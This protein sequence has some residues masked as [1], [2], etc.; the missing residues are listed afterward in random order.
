MRQKAGFRWMSLLLLFCLA[1]RPAQSQR[2]YAVLAGV[3]DYQYDTLFNDLTD[4]RFS[5]DDA[6][7]M[8]HLLK[9]NPGEVV[10]LTDTLATKSNILATARRVFEKAGK[11]DRILF[12][13][14]GHGVPGAFLP[15]DFSGDNFLLHSEIKEAFRLSQ[16][17]V[18]VCIADACYAGSIRRKSTPSAAAPPA[19]ADKGPDVV[20][21]MSSR[22][23][24]TSQEYVRLQRG[25]FTHFLLEALHG[26]A[27][28]DQD[29]QITIT[30][31][32]N[33]LST[34]VS[35]FTRQQQHPIVFG[36]FDKNMVFMQVKEGN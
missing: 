24:E 13:F 36:R 19:S 18:R 31:L 3:A 33:Y 28:V 16:A 26:K 32:F 7:A 23:E 5:D 34:E 8:Y 4:L 17:Q 22:A 20:I 29:R 11:N 2:L 21:I 6:L 10:L 27:D 9:E 12:F 1:A 35:T 25:V 14:S 30:E 15:A